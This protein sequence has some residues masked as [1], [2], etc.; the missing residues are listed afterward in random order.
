MKHG[1]VHLNAIRT[2]LLLC[3]LSCCPC[4]PWLPSASAQFGTPRD[5]AFWGKT[6]RFVDIPSSIGLTISNRWIAASLAN[7]SAVSDWRDLTNNVHWTQSNSSLRPTNGLNGVFFNGATYYLAGTNTWMDNTLV[8][9]ILYESLAA[10]TDLRTNVTQRIISDPTPASDAYGVG[11]HGSAPNYT[12]NWEMGSF[13]FG[14]QTVQVQQA[15]LFWGDQTHVY[16]NGVIAPPL[17]GAAMPQS[18]TSSCQIG[19]DYSGNYFNGYLREF[20]IFTDTSA[21]ASQISN[22]QYYAT[23]YPYTPL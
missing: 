22:L 4:V 18:F 9:F 23:H 2:A 10:T 8:T 3:L 19:A 12:I 17:G 7:G 16:T 21:S 5:L 11:H 13:D 15:V 6:R 1:K 20:I 14:P